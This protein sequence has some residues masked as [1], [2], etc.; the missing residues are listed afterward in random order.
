M[1]Q[2]DPDWM[3][4]ALAQAERRCKGGRACQLGAV[5]SRQGQLVGAGHNSPIGENDPRAH[6]ELAA[7]IRAAG[8]SAWE[9]PAFPECETR[10]DFG[11]LCNVRRCKSNMPE[12]SDW[13]LGVRSPRRVLAAASS[14]CLPSQSSIIIPGLFLG[15][16]HQNRPML[17][18]HFF[19]ETSSVN[20]AL[21]GRISMKTILIDLARQQLDLCDEG[22]L[23]SRWAVSTATN[24]AG[25]RFGSFKHREANIRSVPKLALT[26]PSIRYSLGG[27]QPVKS[28]R[29]NSRHGLPKARLDL[30]PDS[31]AEWNGARVQSLGQRRYHEALYLYSW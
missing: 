13:C 22:R 26:C 23:L 21:I 8:R 16:W 27:A 19:A 25:E 28:G 10:C 1:A 2:S 29:P 18:A 12:S 17:L 15:S 6:A 20:L 7:A 5:V 14:I 11:T 24:G 31:L 4:L 9:L 30:D 3:E